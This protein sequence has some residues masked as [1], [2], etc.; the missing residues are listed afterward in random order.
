IFR[1]NST[2]CHKIN[3]IIL[4]G[5]FWVKTGLFSWCERGCLKIMHLRD[6]LPRQHGVETKA[7]F[8]APLHIQPSDKG[9]ERSMHE[10]LWGCKPWLTGFFDQGRTVTLL[11]MRAGS[12]TGLDFWVTEFSAVPV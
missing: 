2:Q 7:D 1:L 9:I 8:F 10:P 3:L 6:F 11:A 4:G 12:W 5:F